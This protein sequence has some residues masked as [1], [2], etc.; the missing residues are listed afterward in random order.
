MGAKAHFTNR[1]GNLRSLLKAG[2]LAG[3]I[4]VAIR[5]EGDDAFKP[6][7]Y[8]KRIIIERKIVKEGSC[9]YRIMDEH[10]IFL[11]INF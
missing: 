8:G 9:G 10:S 11:F 7:V 4:Q 5:N 6:S 3:S 2:S 1:A